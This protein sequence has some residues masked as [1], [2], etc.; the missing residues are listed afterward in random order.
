M[1]SQQL[2]DIINW[3]VETWKDVLPYWKDKLS[4]YD[5]SSAVCIEIGAR[6]GGI[7]LWMAMNGFQVT[8]SD[9]HY[10]LEDAK[11][12]HQKYG[13]SNNVVYQKIDLLDWNEKNTYDVIIVKSVLG[14]LQN[15][16]RIETALKNIYGNLKEGGILL[17]AENSKAT[18]IHQQFRKRF[19]DWGNSW[20]YFNEQS[21][22]TLFKEMNVMDVKYNGVLAV[23]GNRIGMSKL[24][25]K[26][27]KS[28]L[29]KIV[30]DKM[31]YMLF[32]YAKKQSN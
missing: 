14:A 18:F 24:F 17:F 21:I 26:M 3:D 25:S 23:C 4:D 28:L 20:F 19:T 13:I 15:E 30:P 7:S 8:C 1:D 32:G 11:K 31:K 16:K 10:D 29:N 12:L 2:N 9:I 22:T 27:D 6:D 5:K